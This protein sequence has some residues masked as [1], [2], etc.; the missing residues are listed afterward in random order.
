MFTL[1]L[2]DG[3]DASLVLPIA[4]PEEKAID[5]HVDSLGSRFYLLRLRF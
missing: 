1:E 5:D 2:D 4:N 3:D